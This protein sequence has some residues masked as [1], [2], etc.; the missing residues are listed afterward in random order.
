MR[1]GDCIMHNSNE[2]GIVNELNNFLEGIYMGE[3]IVNSYREKVKDTFAKGKLDHILKSYERHEIYVKNLIKDFGSFPTHSV[4]IE[5]QILELFN[6][7]KNLLIKGDKDLIKHCIKS[8]SIG[9]ENALGFIE[10]QKDYIDNRTLDIMN[11]IVS[12]YSHHISHL[13]EAVNILE[14]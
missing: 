6:N 7:V 3:D 8:I 14:A 11:A 4:G 1:I 13:K 2:N 9:K 5:G 10:E 12:E